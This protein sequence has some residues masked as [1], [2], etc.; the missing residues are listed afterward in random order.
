[1]LL[2]KP[3]RRTIAP[4]VVPLVTT[5]DVEPHEVL[6]DNTRIDVI[7][8]EATHAAVPVKPAV[9]ANMVIRRRMLP[10]KISKEVVLV[11]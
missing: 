1:M 7:C 6:G 3:S 11:C 4:V 10:M 5:V 8:A 2:A 9:V